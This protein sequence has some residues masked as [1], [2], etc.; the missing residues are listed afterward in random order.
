VAPWRSAWAPSIRGTDYTEAR[1]AARC[2]NARDK[3]ADRDAHRWARTWT[4]C[5]W[6]WRIG[7]PKPELVDHAAVLAILPHG[8]GTVTV[9][10]GGLEIPSEER[11]RQHGDGELLAQ[12]VRL[13]I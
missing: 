13:D 3:H 8:T 6:K 1:G 7:V 2:A 4:A 12:L 10:E 9:V 11:H 5:R